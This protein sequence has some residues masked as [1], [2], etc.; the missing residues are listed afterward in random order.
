MASHRNIRAK[1]M[2][3]RPI[4]TA[5]VPALIELRGRTR[6]NAILPERLRALGITP[7]SVARQLATTHRGWLCEEEGRI[8]GFAI[9]DGATGEL[10]VIAVLPEF[11]GRGIGSRLLSLVE[12]WLWSLA[13]KEIWLWTSADERLR[14]FAFYTAQGWCKHEL[15]DGNLYLRKR[16]PGAENS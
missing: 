13:W 2:N 16:R 7:E 11:E 12:E 15:K 8:A 14:A 6:E 10:W 5:D 1:N 4:K 3:V 9:G